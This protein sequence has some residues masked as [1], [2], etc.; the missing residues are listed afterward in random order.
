MHFRVYAGDEVPENLCPFSVLTDRRLPRSDVWKLPQ[1]VHLGDTL[2][3]FGSPF[4]VGVPRPNILHH[5][6]HGLL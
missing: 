6:A 5:C 3:G 1:H 4:R 2:V